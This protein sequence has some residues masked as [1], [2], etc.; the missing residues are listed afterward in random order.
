[1][2]GYDGNTCLFIPNPDTGKYH[3]Y[4]VGNVT[5]TPDGIVDVY[6]A[7][8]GGNGWG[9]IPMVNDDLTADRAVN[10][11]SS[12][13][14]RPEYY[15]GDICRYLSVNRLT[16]GSGLVNTWQMPVSNMFEVSSSTWGFHPDWSGTGSFVEGQIEN[17]TSQT[18]DAFA[19]YTL[20][21]SETVYFPA[22]G[23]RHDDGS[24]GYIG[25]FGYYW[26]S[27]AL[28]DLAFALYFS[29]GYMD[30]ANFN[31]RAYGYSVRCVRDG[32]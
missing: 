1:G 15:Q 21:T 10:A 8:A 16:N 20:P 29:G 14:H 24:Q 17:G 3:K 2:A 9:N 25:D 13:H 4:K 23:Y 30:P 28:G 12:D 26:S 18:A 5:S 19:V 7:K 6:F 22:S 11:L 27:S 32:E 31:N